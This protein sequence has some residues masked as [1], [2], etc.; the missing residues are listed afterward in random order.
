MYHEWVKSL[1][2]ILLAVIILL[3][4]LIGETHLFYYLVL[5]IGGLLLIFQ[6]VHRSR[7]SSVYW[8]WLLF[9]LTAG[10]SVI[11]THSLPL[12]FSFSLYYILGFG[13]FHF[14]FQQQ[15]FSAKEIILVNLIV[16][17]VLVV[18]SAFF[19]FVPAW[20]LLLPGMNLLHASYG[21]N[22]L[23]ALLLLLMPPSWWI[24]ERE[25]GKKVYPALIIPLIFTFALFFSFGRVALLLGFLELLWLWFHFRSRASRNKLMLFLVSPLLVIFV[26]VGIV[27]GVLTFWPGASCPLATYKVQLCKPITHEERL[28]Y[29]SQGIR[30]IKEFPLTGYGPGTFTLVNARY[31]QALY[32]NTAFAHNSFLQMGAEIGIVGGITFIV[33]MG[34]MLV[35][36][37]KRVHA[38]VQEHSSLEH[39]WP[40]Y[41]L[42]GI[43]AIYLNALI[44][45]DWAFSGVFG[46]TMAWLALLLKL[47]DKIQERRYSAILAKFLSWSAVVLLMTVGGLFAIT[48][49]L[50]ERNQASES[51]AIFPYFLPHQRLFL[52]SEQLTPNQ[53]RQVRHIYRYHP[54]LYTIHR[55]EIFHENPELLVLFYEIQPLN[56][57]LVETSIQPTFA[58]QKA[59]WEVLQFYRILTVNPNFRNEIPYSRLVEVSDTAVKMG[60]EELR[61]GDVAQATKWYL[62]GYQIEEW[63][64]NRSL[65]TNLLSSLNAHQVYETLYA[66]RSVSL[67][68]LGAHHVQL[69]A[70]I[71]PKVDELVQEDVTSAKIEYLLEVEK[72][73]NS[74]DYW[75]AIQLGNYYLLRATVENDKEVWLKK[76]RQEFEECQLRFKTAHSDCRYSLEQLDKGHPNFQRYWEVSQIIRGEKEWWE[77]N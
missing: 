76:A 24:A 30:A 7:S 25:L 66:L 41:I 9:F 68:H 47:P 32:Q 3:L 2:F 43:A 18:L 5:V 33:L 44:D 65:D 1:I 61:Q 22:H 26:G 15:L 40:L 19:F 74:I 62:H 55:E 31:K 51:F 42:V 77:F 6:F 64:L 23:A 29:W 35:V 20:A 49:Q 57:L 54:E 58:N 48:N 39:Q 37:I 56:S 4:L 36:A 21:H 27:K 59:E 8:L 71:Q 60:N 12:S 13:L 72:N 10:M 69:L 28:Y 53:K 70:F 73:L 75:P 50:I 16:G 46:I 17:C 52:S 67:T 45:F 11:F 34:G 38:Y 63:S 14:F